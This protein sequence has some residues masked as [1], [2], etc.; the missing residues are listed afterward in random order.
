MQKASATRD[1]ESGCR[2][3]S[4][5]EKNPAHAEESRIRT[6]VRRRIRMEDRKAACWDLMAHKDTRPPVNGG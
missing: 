1:L 3:S 6:S 2:A 4:R 5:Q